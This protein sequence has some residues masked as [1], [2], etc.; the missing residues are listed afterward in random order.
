MAKAGDS[1]ESP[2]IG[3]RIV[4]LKTARDTNGALLTMYAGWAAI[5]PDHA[6]VLARARCTRLG[7]PESH[8]AAQARE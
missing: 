4:F 8:S 7:L 5:L 1:I 2:P 6:K 3:D